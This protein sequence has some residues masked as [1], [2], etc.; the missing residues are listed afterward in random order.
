VEDADKCNTS[1]T[2]EAESA[3]SSTDSAYGI[4]AGFL[5]V[6]SIAQSIAIIGLKNAVFTRRDHIFGVAIIPM[7]IQNGVSVGV[8][9]ATSKLDGAVLK[10]IKTGLDSFI[11]RGQYIAEISVVYSITD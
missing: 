7:I 1:E 10:T 8:K 9:F 11:H 5:A 2:Q 4:K 3:D 6:F